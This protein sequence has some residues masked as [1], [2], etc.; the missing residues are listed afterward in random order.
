M[1]I[2][3]HMS[4]KRYLRKLYILKDYLHYKCSYVYGRK[5]QKKKIVDQEISST[6]CN[7]ERIKVCFFNINWNPRIF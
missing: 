4:Y 2:F 3:G 7:P 1:E 6:C 5:L